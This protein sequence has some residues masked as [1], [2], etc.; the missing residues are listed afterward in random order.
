MTDP[1]G[2]KRLFGLSKDSLTTVL[3]AAV[4]IGIGWNKFSVLEET[5]KDLKAQIAQNQQTT[6]V[7]QAGFT[8]LL[9]QLGKRLDT[10]NV[11]RNALDQRVLII[12][13][14]LNESDK[15]KK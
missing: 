10:E 1:D 9:E 7:G 14:R 15:H 13:T 4:L 6:T 11:S 8:G 2:I 3:T 12:E 5:V